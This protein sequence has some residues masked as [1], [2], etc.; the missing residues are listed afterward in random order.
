MKIINEFL[1]DYARHL[2]FI[3]V[4][5]GFIVLMFVLAFLPMFMFGWGHWIIGSLLILLYLAPLLRLFKK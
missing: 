5:I 4:W 1:D 3:L 2:A